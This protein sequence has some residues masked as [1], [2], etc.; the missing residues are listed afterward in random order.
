MTLKSI[1]IIKIPFN[2]RYVGNLPLATCRAD[3]DDLRRVLALVGGVACDAVTSL[4][5][6]GKRHF[7][8]ATVP[9]S[10]AHRLMAASAAA[11][12]DGESTES[13]LSYGGRNL[14]VALRG[15]SVVKRLAD[16]LK[17]DRFPPAR[18]VTLSRLRVSILFP[19]FRPIVTAILSLNV[20]I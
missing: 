4:H 2:Y 19:L 18:Y 5:I 8:F 7:A 17:A 11:N 1:L 12:N 20:C 10:A 16:T 9:A 15:G 14:T 6:N 13:A 3:T